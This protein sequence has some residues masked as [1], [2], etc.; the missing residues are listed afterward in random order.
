MHV[1]LEFLAWPHAPG[2]HTVDSGSTAV[3]QKWESKQCTSLLGSF[4]CGELVGFGEF[5]FSAWWRN[6]MRLETLVWPCTFPCE[7]CRWTESLGYQGFGR[8]RSAESSGRL[9][10]WLHTDFDFQVMHTVW[11]GVMSGVRHLMA[12]SQANQKMESGQFGLSPL[13]S[14]W[15]Q[16]E[17][18]KSAR[19]WEFMSNSCFSFFSCDTCDVLCWTWRIDVVRIRVSLMKCIYVYI[20]I[21]I[22]IYIYAYIAVVLAIALRK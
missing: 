8:S 18:E 1:E 4:L 12:W 17:R 9:A 13:S 16:N 3:A 10:S 22:Y 19:L 11:S 6:V 5:V 7:S 2:W 14:R 20:C 15:F 21:Y